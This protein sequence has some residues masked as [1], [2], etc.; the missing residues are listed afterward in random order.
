MTPVTPEAEVEEIEY[1]TIASYTWADL[2]LPPK[3]TS[4]ASE[5]ARKILGKFVKRGN[6]GF[7][8]SMQE[9]QDGCS[10][11]EKHITPEVENEINTMIGEA[12]ALVANA[13][14]KMGKGAM[15]FQTAVNVVVERE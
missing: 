9:L 15:D 8:I 5:T 7:A 3:R 12:H 6:L 11:E 13:E 10:G 2:G 14:E 4:K 1:E